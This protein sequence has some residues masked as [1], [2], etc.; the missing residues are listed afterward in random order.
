MNMLSL[1]EVI[2]LFKN[3]VRKMHK[4]IKAELEK[5]WKQ[6]VRVRLHSV[7]VLGSTST[8]ERGTIV[9]C[10]A[11]IGKTKKS[12]TAVFNIL[13]FLLNEKANPKLL[14]LKLSQ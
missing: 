11:Q 2:T 3:L 10:T 13:P 7:T 9:H 5:R 8:L 4:L 14:R 1:S 6:K 12:Y